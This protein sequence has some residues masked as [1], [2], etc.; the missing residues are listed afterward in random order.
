MEKMIIIDIS[1]LP[2]QKALELG[3]EDGSWWC[4]NKEAYYEFYYL[5]GEF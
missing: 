5:E 1:E 3:I 2:T 4:I